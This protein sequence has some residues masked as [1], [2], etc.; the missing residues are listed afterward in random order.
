MISSTASS[1]LRFRFDDLGVLVVRERDVPLLSGGREPVT[2]AV[3][4]WF[5]PPVTVEVDGVDPFE[6]VNNLD[7]PIN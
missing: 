2:V 6:V 1:D 4:E 3:E 5:R 7:F